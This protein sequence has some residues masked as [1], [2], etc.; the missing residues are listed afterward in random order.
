MATRAKGVGGGRQPAVSRHPDQG[1]F[2]VYP[3]LDFGLFL[4][5]GDGGL[6]YEQ[7]PGL[8]PCPEAEAGESGDLQ[9]SSTI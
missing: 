7:S 4:N 2:Q 9:P 5:A 1:T 3:A 6:G 8:Q